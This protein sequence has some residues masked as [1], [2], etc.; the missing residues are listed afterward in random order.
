[1]LKQICQEMF[2]AYATSPTDFDHP[3]IRA[4]VL[5]AHLGTC[6]T[7]A[8]GRDSLPRQAHC[9]QRVAH[10]GT[11]CRAGLSELSPG[12]QPQP[13]ELSS[14]GPDLTAPAGLYLPPL[15]RVGVRFGRHHRT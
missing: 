3:S 9:D 7:S 14:G 4:A 10:P 5:E 2:C 8:V 11:E 1:M 15:R 13:L 12:A 6:P